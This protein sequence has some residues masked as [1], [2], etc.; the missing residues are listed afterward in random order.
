MRLEKYFFVKNIGEKQLKKAL[1][2]V[3]NYYHNKINYA[4]EVLVF[5]SHHEKN[6]YLI[7]FKNE[8]DLA[9]FKRYF[10]FLSHTFFRSTKYDIKG[11]WKV[12]SSD[13]P[14]E[15][16]DHPLV[17][18]RIMFFQPTFKDEKSFVHL[19]SQ[20]NEIYRMSAASDSR[21]EKT[22][23]KEP[24]YEEKSQY[25]LNKFVHLWTH[26]SSAKVPYYGLANK[27]MGRAIGLAMVIMWLLIGLIVYF[28]SQD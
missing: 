26:T 27:K 1:G 15:Q 4:Q 20:D 28:L 3:S 10:H 8:I 12:E 7:Y 25:Y 19:V 13:F 24:K 17:N 16:T 9:Q 14:E 11:Y 5:D 21:L 6:A 22:N 23:L 18:K 2:F